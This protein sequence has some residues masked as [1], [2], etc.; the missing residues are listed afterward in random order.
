MGNVPFTVY[1]ALGYLSAGAILLTAATIAVVGELP[2]ERTIA[3]AV[4]IAVGSYLVGHI[5]SSLSM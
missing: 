1:D 3:T 5:V 2:T 4:A